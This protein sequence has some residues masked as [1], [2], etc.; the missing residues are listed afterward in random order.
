MELELE[1]YRGEELTY[2]TSMEFIGLLQRAA[3]VHFGDVARQGEI[4][5]RIEEP[6]DPVAYPGPPK[7]R[8]LATSCGHCT[9]RVVQNDHTL[10]E[11]RFPV[12][13][14]L[15][16]V[17]AEDMS[18]LEA[19]ETLWS[20]RLLRR[21]ALALLLVTT[22]I[23][24]LTRHERP[25]PK[26]EGAVEVDPRER[27]HRPFTLT[28]VADADAQVVEPGKLGIPPDELGRLTILMSR[29]IH[30]RFVRTMPLSDRM[31]EGG[32]MLGR[33]TKARDDAHLVEVTH[34]TPAHR[35]GAGMVHFTFTGESF[36]AAAQLIEERGL[37]EELLGWYHTHL[38]GV[39]HEMGLSSIDIDLHLATFQKQWQVAALLNLSRDGRT[40][41]FY[42]RGDDGLK[43]YPQWIS[44]DSGRYRP[45]RHSMGGD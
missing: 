31:E 42:G 13:E 43:E 14:F 9:L 28:Q 8:N 23:R 24:T 41:R 27:R 38:F 37:G 22:A 2:Y 45:A 11:Q 5:F 30:R 7:I 18:K 35:S 44:D 32:F 33:V 21:R 29:D 26:V 4:Q 19:E 34:I 25:E 16:P 10:H 1:L 6:G 39:D 12:S 17:L 36:F 15:G 3:L 20:F 40:L